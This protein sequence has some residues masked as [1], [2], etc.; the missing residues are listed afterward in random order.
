MPY[1]AYEDS[2]LSVE[3]IASLLSRVFISPP[4]GIDIFN[5]PDVTSIQ[6]RDQEEYHD[7]V[8]RAGEFVEMYNS[9]S[10]E[11]IEAVARY[12]YYRT[13]LP[14]P[15][16]LYAEFNYDPAARLMLITMVVPDFVRLNVTKL[17]KTG[18]TT[19]VAAAEKAKQC[20]KLLYSLT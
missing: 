4:Y 9:L 2:P 10:R 18:K 13:A 20:E 12:T 11:G 15:L 3:T 1:M 6:E 16:Q 8:I 5:L 19:E 14:D 17:L 7:D